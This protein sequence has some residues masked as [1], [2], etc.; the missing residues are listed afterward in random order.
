MPESSPAKLIVQLADGSKQEHELIT[1]DMSVGRDAG[2]DIHIPSRYVS[3]RH[4]LISFRDG[5]FVIRDERSTNGLQIN[6][7]LVQEPYALSHGDRV[8]VGDVSLTYEDGEDPSATAVYAAVPKPA[9]EPPAGSVRPAGLCTI[10]FTDLVDST[11][12]VTRLGDVAGQ[13]WIRRH[14][15]ILREQ[16]GRFQGVEEKWTGDGFVATFASARAALHCAVAIQSALLVYNRDHPDEEMHVRTGLNTGEVLREGSELFGNAVILAAR[17][18]GRAGPDQIL[19]SELMQRLVQ[20]SG[21]FR[22]VDRGPFA[23]KGLSQRQ[24]LY[25]VLWDEPEA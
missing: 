22:I 10:L 21:E 19:L 25:E 15:S 24:R 4:A 6:G 2:C 12:Q 11:R 3:R 17:V 13:R 20:P 23:I 9:E 1:A 18:M 7:D 5:R 14:T 16:F 8:V